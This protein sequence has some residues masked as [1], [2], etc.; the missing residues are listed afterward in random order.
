MADAQVPDDGSIPPETEVWRRI[1][2]W[3]WT[4]DDSVT[5]GH[6]PSTDAFDDQELSVVIANEC[7]GGLD[8]LLEGLVGFGVAS[9]T[10]SEIRERAWGIVRVRDE[11]LPGHAHVTG[12]KTKGKRSSLAKRCRM[13]KMPSAGAAAPNNGIPSTPVAPQSG[14]SESA[15]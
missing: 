8:T 3:Q 7:T 5:L 13:I 10:V 6:R 4:P 1:P 14:P 11:K 2:P 15:P 9:F 12:N